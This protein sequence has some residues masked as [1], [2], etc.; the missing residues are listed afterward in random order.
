MSVPTNKAEFKEWCL[1]RLGKPVIN[2]DVSESQIDDRV[3]EAMKFYF[4]Y[5]PNATEKLY[6]KHQITQDDIDNKYITMPENVIGA[7]RIFDGN[8]GG[9]GSWGDATMFSF[10]YQFYMNDMYTWTGVDLVPYWMAQEN[11]Q[12]MEQILNG[13][14]PIRYQR[15]TNKL[16]VDMNWKNFGVGQ[17]LIVEA[18]EVI[19]P[20]VYPDV[21][22]ERWLLKYATALIKRQWGSNLSKFDGV[23]LVGGVVFNGKA[24]YEEADAEVDATEKDMIDNSPLEFMIG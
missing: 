14:K 6:Y 10:N 1:R 12:F 15:N 23:Q 19:D 13:L 17:Y 24:I 8:G 7:V 11:M 22:G 3:D 21:W 18:Y 20:E 9:N 2:I 5:H 4:D 16:Y